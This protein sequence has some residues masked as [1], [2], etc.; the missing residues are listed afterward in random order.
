MQ[1]LYEYGLFFAKAITIVIA[2]AVIIALIAGASAKPKTGKDTLTIKNLSDA[3][4]QQRLSLLS[5]SL[6]KDE[7]K[8]LEKA[9][10]KSQKE[11]DE[12]NNAFVLTFKGA[13]DAKEVEALRKE[14]TAVIQVAKP[15]DEVVIR[16]ESG[17]G[18]V[19]GYGLAAS[20]L[21]R[22]KEAKLNV[23]VSVDK[24]AAS[25][26]YMMAC[27]SD[28]LVCAPFAIIGSIG[29]IAQVPIINKVL[30]K[31]DIEF[32]QITAGEFKRTLTMYGENTDA[33]RD[34]FKQEVDQIHNL[35][36]KHVATARPELD[37]SQVAT[38]ET[39]FGYDALEMGLVD[40]IATSDDLLLSLNHIEIKD[41]KQSEERILILSDTS[42]PFKS[43]LGLL[44]A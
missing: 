43:D 7:F 3:L 22:L 32:E 42:F 4:Q 28:K 38:G 24:I 12:K 30:K 1:F 44:S 20:Q 34:K 2:I 14:V 23:T 9:E 31:N 33:G 27:V 16:L 18:V 15:N 17:G 8:K 26:G 39:W 25:G 6:P 37:I 40:E 10:K 13:E 19:H 41:L 21:S 36:R 11:S 5:E 29:V 35:F